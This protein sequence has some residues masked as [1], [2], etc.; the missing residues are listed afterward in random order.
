M[1]GPRDHVNAKAGPRR[2]L[3][4]GLVAPNDPR[5]LDMM[6]WQAKDLKID[7]WKGYTADGISGRYPSG[8]YY[9]GWDLDD[10][11]VAHPVDGKA[12]KSGLKTF[13]IPKGGAPP[14]LDEKHTRPPD[15]EP[16]GPPDPDLTLILYHS[17]YRRDA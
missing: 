4:P 14:R 12:R 6:E 1:V 11:K 9:G 5:N 13:L 16:A 17:A 15:L 2:M 8:G 7:S 10:V 3:S